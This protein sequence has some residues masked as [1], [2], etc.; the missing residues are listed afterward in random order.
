MNL[1]EAIKKS[2]S[3]N[4]QI[5]RKSWKEST[6][7]VS[8]FFVGHESQGMVFTTSFGT[9]WRPRPEDILAEDWELVEEAV[10]EIDTEPKPPQHMEAPVCKDSTR[11]AVLALSIMALAF[12]IL[13]IVLK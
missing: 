5:K 13:A 3:K 4:K 8:E 1:Q 10:S 7:Y 11:I 2:T 12:S 6:V 9:V